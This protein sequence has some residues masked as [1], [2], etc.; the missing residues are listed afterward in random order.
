M[1][2]LL[3]YIQM[4]T[5]VPKRVSK[6]LERRLHKGSPPSRASLLVWVGVQSLVKLLLPSPTAF[7]RLWDSASLRGRAQCQSR[8]SLCR[9]TK[10]AAQ[11]QSSRLGPAAS[12]A[13]CAR[14]ARACSPESGAARKGRVGP[15][16]WSETEVQPG[17]A[18]VC[19][20]GKAE[21]LR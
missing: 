21:A 6:D 1:G 20:L 9:P 14:G 11:R 7:Q 16:Q 10:C 13:P 4:Y 17:L 2:A 3:I 18:K 15:S 8:G 19:R 12:R 5:L